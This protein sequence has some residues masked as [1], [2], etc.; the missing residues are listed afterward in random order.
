MLRFAF[1]GRARARGK[2]AAPTALSQALKT[3]PAK[4]ETPAPVPRAPPA[5]VQVDKAL[6]TRLSP[7]LDLTTTG[8]RKAV[9]PPQ[10]LLDGIA[11]ILKGRDLTAIRNHFL[12]MEA[13]L[14]ARDQS[15]IRELRGGSSVPRSSY[16]LGSSPP[17]LYGP[18]ETLAFVTYRTLPLYA[19]ISHLFK[20]VAGTMPDFA[21]KSLLDFG[22]G[23]CFRA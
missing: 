9:A 6:A 2:P 15:M 3:P 23:A 1:L 12:D 4:V 5:P 21:P 13:S 18:Q 10:E 19:V 17:L 20:E 14:D 7:F 8:S 16:G 22:S 11:T